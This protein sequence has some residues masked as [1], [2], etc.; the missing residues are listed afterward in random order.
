MPGFRNKSRLRLRVTAAAE[1]MVRGGHPW[2]FSNSVRDQNRDGETGELAVIF[3][4]QDK[5]LAIG[6]FDPE[7]PIRVRILHVG[8]PC[9]IDADLVAETSGS[10]DCATERIV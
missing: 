7:S 4:R 1:S 3:D 10:R 2:V 5:F 6:L 8:K 9:V